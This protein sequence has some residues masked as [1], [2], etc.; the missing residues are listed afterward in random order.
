MAPKASKER[1][2]DAPSSTSSKAPGSGINAVLS[3]GKAILAEKKARAE[4]AAAGEDY[5]W[6]LT[7]LLLE[8][9]SCDLTLGDLMESERLSKSKAV[10]VLLRFRQ[11]AEE[12]ASAADAANPKSGAFLPQMAKKPKPASKPGL[13]SLPAAATASKPPS[14]TAETGEDGKSSKQGSVKNKRKAQEEEDTAKEAEPTAEKRKK[15]KNK[16]EDG[17]DVCL[18]AASSPAAKECKGGS[19]KRIK[20]QDAVEAAVASKPGDATAE[21]VPEKKKKKGESAGKTDQEM[22][23]DMAN[24]VD[25]TL[26]D[27][28]VEEILA[29]D[30]GAGA[31]KCKDGEK[32]QMNKEKAEKKERKRKEKENRRELKELIAE[33]EE[34]VSKPEPVDADVPRRVSSKRADSRSGPNAEASMPTK[35]QTSSQ[36]PEESVVPAPVTP[37]RASSEDRQPDP[38]ESELDSQR[39]AW[40]LACK[41][42]VKVDTFATLS[43]SVSL[44]RSLYL[45]LLLSLSVSLSLSLSLSLPLSFSVCLPHFLSHVFCSLMS[46]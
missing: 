29:L 6:P 23:K 12:A 27:P 2:E 33:I 18:G 24:D 16:P 37:S 25:E 14:N 45:L 17:G 19:K 10:K 34:Q 21:P 3:R 28:V 20:E 32:K 13:A 5:D 15:N 42:H 38:T 40:L 36:G 43:V 31:A 9:G 35:P 7:T 30:V 1:A 39:R 22:S 41:L 26:V 46:V 8:D 4:K 44:S 11:E